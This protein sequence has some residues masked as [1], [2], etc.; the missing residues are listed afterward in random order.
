[1]SKNFLNLGRY[2]SI[3]DRLM[4]MYD[5]RNLADFEIGWG[6]QTLPSSLAY[7]LILHNGWQVAGYCYFV[8]ESNIK[9]EIEKKK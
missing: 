5:D 6:F 1:M 3:L 8:S 9:G 2:I 7:P 4:K